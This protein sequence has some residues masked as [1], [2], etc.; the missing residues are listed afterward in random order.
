MK[1]NKQIKKFDAE[2]GKVLNLMINSL[3]TNKEIF[4]REL[5][6]NASDACDKLRYQIIDKP[7]LLGD[8]NDEFKINILIDK[9]NKL[10][11]ISD[12][13]I[14]MNKE[15]LV[16]N[17][18]TIASSGTQKFIEQFSSNKNNNLNLIGQFGVGFYS[19]FMVSESITVI[20]SK[21]GEKE[22]Y[23]WHSDGKGEYSIE[24]STQELKRGTKITLKIKE[25]ELEFLELHKIKHIIRTYSDHVAFPIE[26]TEDDNESEIINKASAIWTRSTS[27]VTQKEYEEFFNHVSHFP[28]KPWLTLHNK[29][30]GMIEYTNLL[31]IP[32]TKP[33][34]LFH[35]DRKTRVKLYIKRVFISEEGNDLI[36]SY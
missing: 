29:A 11:I 5:I 1:S 13:G 15:D 24:N 7:E 31:F 9:T 18:G 20:T 14:G 25:S 36:P 30:E 28:G 23:E 8:D 12:N 6:S 17:L 3:Y 16:H 35:P 26:L 21:A 19:A 32:D 34:D 2:I 27:E 10:V 22:V 4:L 33:F